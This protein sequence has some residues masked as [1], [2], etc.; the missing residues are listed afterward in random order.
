M[1]IKNHNCKFT[2]LNFIVQT[3]SKISFHY[4]HHVQCMYIQYNNVTIYI[5]L[6]HVKGTG[7]EIMVIVID[8]IAVDVTD[9][10]DVVDQDQDRDQE[11]GKEEIETGTDLI[12]VEIGI[13]LQTG[14]EIQNLLHGVRIENFQFF[15]RLSKYNV[16]KEKFPKKRKKNILFF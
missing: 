16:S 4:E 6:D 10:Q 1:N 11:K 12:E 2:Y 5:C 14:M 9:L 15:V 3:I 8:V 13:E 7:I